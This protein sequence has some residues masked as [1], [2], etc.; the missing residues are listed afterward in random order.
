MTYL[1]VSLLHLQSN[2]LTTH[3][4]VVFNL[5]FVQVF[6]FIMRV[7]ALP[8]TMRLLV[9]TSQLLD[10]FKLRPRCTQHWVVNGNVAP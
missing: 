3:L 10:T 7:A 9:L 1:G 4:F 8:F 2:P 5:L 6:H